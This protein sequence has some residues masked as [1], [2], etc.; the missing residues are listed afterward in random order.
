LREV[1]ESEESALPNGTTLLAVDRTRLAY[2]RTLMAWIRTATSLITFGFSIYKFFQ[3]E[4]ANGAS[5]SKRLIGPREFALL[6]IIIGL[7]SRLIATLE[8]RQNLRALNAQYGGSPAAL[9]CGAPEQAATNS[10]GFQMSQRA[11]RSM[12]CTVA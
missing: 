12:S 2:E 4:L 7:A 11:L 6:M 8:R 1:T 5:R 10:R 9:G 3:I